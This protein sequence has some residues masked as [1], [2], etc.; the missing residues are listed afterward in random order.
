MFENLSPRGKRI[1]FNSIIVLAVMLFIFAYFIGKSSDSEKKDKKETSQDTEEVQQEDFSYSDLNKVEEEESKDGEH[2]TQENPETDY[3]PNAKQEVNVLSDSFTEDQINQ[4]KKNVQQFIEAYYPFDGKNP[5]QHIEKAKQFMT[6]K[7]QKEV[8][9]QIVRPTNDYYSRKPTKIEIYEPYNP[10][11]GKMNLVARVEGE[12][13]NSKGT[14]TKKE[15][16][17]YNITLVYED[18]TF[19]V[20]NYDYTSLKGDT[21]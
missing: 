17:E 7:M 5:T 10:E 4:A 21:E 9:G 11:K 13:Y 1:V 15:T 19:K 3:N 12:V 20:S 16:V 6:E 14:L 8:E 2:Y 18:N